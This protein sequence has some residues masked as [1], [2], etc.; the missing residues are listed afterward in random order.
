MTDF[1]KNFCYTETKH[2]AAGTATDFN[3]IPFIRL[4]GKNT[5]III[6]FDGIIINNISLA[7]NREFG[8]PFQFY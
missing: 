4:D 1:N 8:I 7:M 3:S 6:S 2:T 5:F